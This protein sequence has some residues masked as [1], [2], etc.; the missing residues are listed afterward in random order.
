MSVNKDLCL[1]GI[2]RDV[3]LWLFPT[4]RS[5]CQG[6]KLDKKRVPEIGGKRVSLVLFI[7]N[8]KKGME[9]D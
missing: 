1:S 8:S 2:L 7:W 3:V 4:F 6:L 5:N 9:K